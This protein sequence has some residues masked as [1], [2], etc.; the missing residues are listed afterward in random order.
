MTH[1]PHPYSPKELAVSLYLTRLALNPRHGGVGYDLRDRQGLHQ[2]VMHLVPDQL[3]EATAARR[4]ARVLYRLE[5]T[6]DGHTL[7]IQS[8]GPLDLN[9][10]PA[11]YA[12]HTDERRL[13]V[14]LEWI[15][16]GARVHYRLDGRPEGTAP[17]PQD[18]HGRRG[19]GKRFAL[20]GQQAAGWWEKRAAAAGL[21][22]HSSS[23][24]SLPR[25][26]AWRK[27]EAG[28]S[29]RT[30]LYLVRYEGIAVVTDPD[31]LRQAIAEGIGR[32][33]AYGAG[34]LSLAPLASA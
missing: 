33:K 32:G 16:E 12:A 18:E 28:K 31:V 27:D 21:D 19:R 11:G 1:L 13:G 8:G 24:V 17:G 7:I 14:L 20:R 34:L 2:R 15:S 3:G 26:L 25:A 6:D 22:V 23:P 30:P 29:H 5:T 10:L 4:A 9:A